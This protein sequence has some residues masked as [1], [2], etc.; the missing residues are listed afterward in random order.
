MKIS[1]FR[2]VMNVPK[3]GENSSPKMTSTS[4]SPNA[5]SSAERSAST[6]GEAFGLVRNAISSSNRQSASA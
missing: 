4:I 3:S 5:K 2:I 6:L 1:T